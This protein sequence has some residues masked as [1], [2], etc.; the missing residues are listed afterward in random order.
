[1]SETFGAKIIAALAATSCLLL[2]PALS[3]RIPANCDVIGDSNINT[4]DEDCR[5]LPY[6]AQVIFNDSNY[7]W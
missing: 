6:Y 1:M 7:S 5:A 3:Y 4:S 2:Q